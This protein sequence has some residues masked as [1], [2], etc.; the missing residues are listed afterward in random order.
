MESIKSMSWVRGDF[1]LSGISKIH[2]NFKHVGRTRAV[3]HKEH[4]EIR[5]TLPQ[6]NPPKPQFFSREPQPIL[7]VLSRRLLAADRDFR[8]LERQELDVY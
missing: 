7:A 4:I 3:Q 5:I 6:Q 1:S 8:A 2:P